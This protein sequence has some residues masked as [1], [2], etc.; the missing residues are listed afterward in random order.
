MHC[1]NMVIKLSMSVGI[2]DVYPAMVVNFA[3]SRK[4]KKIAACNFV[5]L[6]E[7]K[8]RELLDKKGKRNKKKEKR[9]EK[10]Y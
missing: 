3:F 8:M 7:K 6:G 10:N 4:V 9:K 2:H 1:P 5:S